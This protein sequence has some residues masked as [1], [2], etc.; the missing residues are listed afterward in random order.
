MNKIKNIYLVLT[1][2]QL[3]QAL[4]ISSGV[5]NDSATI[6]I[7][8][9]VRKGNR[10][11]TI[12]A[13][14]LWNLGN[15]EIIILDN[16]SPNEIAE[17]VLNENPKHFLFFQGGDAL[18]A[19][20]AHTLAEAGVEISLGPDG[21]GPYAIFNKRFYLLSLIMDSCKQNYFLLK[22]NL[23]SG[24]LHR[25]DYYKYGN[26]RFIKNL[27]ITH[28]EQYTHRANNKV[29]ILKLPHFNE[30]VLDFVEEIFDFSNPF[31][32]ENVIY[33]FNQPLKPGVIETE[34]TFVKDVLKTFPEKALIIKLHPLTS[35]DA[36]FFYKQ[37]VR[38]Q[39]IE[40]NVPAELLLLTLQNCIVFTGWSSVLITENKS[41]NYYFN[42]PI[43]KALNNPSINQIDILNLNHITMVNT[44]TEMKF[45]NE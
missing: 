14:K 25:F 11:M 3:L 42:F 33:F 7:I 9:I 45:P 16:R 22:N 43:Y 17:L 44:P 12:D 8:Y 10:L 38:V 23:F 29:R 6:N 40:S 4:N 39:I 37:L 1:E 15:I 28:P 30:Y 27:W 5:Y 20:L 2:Y 18:N 31:P 24:K 26:H 13:G 34:Y 32:I 35:E 36:K 21:Y 19:F 41:C